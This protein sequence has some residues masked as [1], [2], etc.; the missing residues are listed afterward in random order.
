MPAR[1]CQVTAIGILCRVP[2]IVLAGVMLGI[3]TR[4]CR[5]D[6]ILLLVCEDETI[7]PKTIGTI[8]LSV[9]VYVQYNTLNAV[10]S[11]EDVRGKYNERIALYGSKVLLVFNILMVVAYLIGAFKNIIMVIWVYQN[12]LLFIGNIFLAA[13]ALWWFPCDTITYEVLQSPV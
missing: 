11:D 10:V 6:S 13:N 4:Y 1:R 2:I 5:F 3:G 12:A 7:V 8:G 9:W